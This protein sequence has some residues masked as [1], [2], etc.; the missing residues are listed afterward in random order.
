M[1]IEWHLNVFTWIKNGWENNIFCS[2]TVKQDPG[3]NVACKTEMIMKSCDYTVKILVLI[4]HWTLFV[5]II[6]DTDGYTSC[7]DSFS[8]PYS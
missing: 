5:E 2:I 4:K 7:D 8:D 6:T 1:S 3:F